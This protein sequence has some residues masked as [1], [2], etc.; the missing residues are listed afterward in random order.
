MAHALPFQ[1]GELPFRLVDTDSGQEWL[2]AGLKPERTVYALYQSTAAPPATAAYAGMV[3]HVGAQAYYYYYDCGAP[4]PACFAPYTVHSV[5]DADARQAL[6][7]YRRE[8]PRTWGALKDF[9]QAELRFLTQ[10]HAMGRDG[11]LAS[12]MGLGKTVVAL[13]FANIIRARTVL[14]VVCNSRLKTQWRAECRTWGNRAPTFVQSGRDNPGGIDNV[15]ISFQNLATQTKNRAKWLQRKWDLLI[16][17]EAQKIKTASSQRTKAVGSITAARR[18]YL[19]GTPLMNNP[20]ELYTLALHLDPLVLGANRG[21]FRLAFATAHERERHNKYVLAG[22][23]NRGQDVSRMELPPQPPSNWEVALRGFLMRF[24]ARHRKDDVLDLPP[25]RR[26]IITTTHADTVAFIKSA[27]QPLLDDLYP[28]LPTLDDVKRWLSSNPDAVKNIFSLHNTLSALKID[29][30]IQHAQRLTALK[31]TIIWALHQR[32]QDAL[33]A[34]LPA[35]AYIKSGMTEVAADKQLALFMDG[36]AAA[37]ILPIRAA[38]EGL[39]LQRAEQCLFTELDWVPARH[40]QA[41]DRCY[42]IGTT[43]PIDAYYLVLQKSL[44]GGIHSR[45][46]EKHQLI[47]AVID[48]D[49]TAMFRERLVG[50]VGFLEN[51]AQALLLALAEA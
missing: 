39:N 36:E 5:L 22:L 12:D 23:R 6:Q 44:D 14:I 47:A 42:R 37:I 19:T 2:L 35:A 17:D 16:V 10:L 48:G 40:L 20:T 43:T 29:A 15:I 46:Q 45:L 1:H 34:A 32:M 4:L 18:L 21:R 31:P 38:G 33:R 30:A 26:H 41:E 9:Q 11:L 24:T 49:E 51:I 13:V 8:R 28:H 27:L 7:H 25:K 50:D 3:R